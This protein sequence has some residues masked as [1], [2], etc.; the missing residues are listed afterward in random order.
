M[1]QL[2]LEGRW[3]SAPERAEVRGRKSEVGS[4]RSE[5]RGRKSVKGTAHGAKSRGHGEKYYQGFFL[6]LCLI[7]HQQQNK[8]KGLLVYKV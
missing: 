8:Q 7:R 1:V 3:G 6:P 5:G 2:K 4:Q